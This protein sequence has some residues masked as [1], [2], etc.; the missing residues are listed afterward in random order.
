MMMTRK[1]HPLAQMSGA[2]PV[3]VTVAINFVQ[4]DVR[5]PDMSLRAPF[6]RVRIESATFAGGPVCKVIAEASENQFWQVTLNIEDGAELGGLIAQAIT[7]AH[8]L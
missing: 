8:N 6:D 7:A 3:T 1:Y 5:N 4:F 2:L